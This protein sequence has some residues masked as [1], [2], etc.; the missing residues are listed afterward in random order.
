MEHE[1]QNFDEAISEF[2]KFLYSQQWPKEIRWIPSGCVVFWRGHMFVRVKNKQICES[3]ARTIYESG[4]NRS[5]G[6]TLNGVCHSSIET[7]A[8]V[9]SPLNEDASERLMYDANRPKMSLSSKPNKATYVSSPL[10]WWLLSILGK[11][12]GKAPGNNDN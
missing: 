11:T 12:W 10:Y 1:W 3:E 5:L 7:W 2:Q 9:S 6:V 4:L 8:Y